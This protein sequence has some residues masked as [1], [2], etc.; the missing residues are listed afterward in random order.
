MRQGKWPKKVSR[1]SLLPD[2]ELSPE[3]SLVFA[4]LN[5]LDQLERDRV[6]G[7]DEAYGSAPDNQYLHRSIRKRISE[8]DA[9]VLPG[10]IFS[11]PAEMYEVR[12]SWFDPVTNSQQ[13]K[14]QRSRKRSP[15]E[16]N[17]PS[18]RLRRQ[19]QNTADTRIVVH[20]MKEEA[21]RLAK[22][23]RKHYRLDGDIAYYADDEASDRGRPKRRSKSH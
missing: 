3:S 21:A 19:W 23:A 22:K 5:L 9:T 7:Q 15:S 18:M 11:D 20:Q 1:S 6:P 2:I 13:R 17:S 16:D 4:R 8:N 14:A 10:K 12:P